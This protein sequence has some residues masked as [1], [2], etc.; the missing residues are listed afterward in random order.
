MRAAFVIGGLYHRANGI[1]WIM[2]DLAASLHTKNV[3]VEVF[4]ADCRRPG[5]TSIGEIFESPTLWNSEAGSW[6][7]GLSWSPKLHDRINNAIKTFHVVHNHSVWMLPN[8]YATRCAKRIGIPVTYTL[9]GSLEPWA[10]QHS[11]WKKRI[12]GL[13]FQYKDLHIADCLHVNSRRELENARQLGFRNPI[14]VIPNGIKFKDS[15]NARS[16]PSLLDRFPHFSDRK[17]FLFMARLHKKKGLDLVLRAWKKVC[18]DFPDWHFIIAGPDDGFQSACFSLI[19]SLGLVQK[20]TMTGRLDGVD[21]HDVFEIS[22]FFVQPSYSEGFSM[23]VMEAMAANLPALISTGCNFHEAAEHGAAVEVA[24]E[25]EQVNIA[26]RKML[27]MSDEER[28]L[29]GE[30]GRDLISRKYTWDKV[31]SMTKEMYQWMID[32]ASKPDFIDLN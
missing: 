31:A 5:L 22:R 23:S 27:E 24:T 29:M 21:K 30:R 25:Q 13:L 4:A 15:E 1:A 6:L 14:A 28:M 26:L 20:V 12:V 10:M 3:G 8:S 16:D 9:H 18:A 32:R 19:E 11:S 2:R 17:C 7:G